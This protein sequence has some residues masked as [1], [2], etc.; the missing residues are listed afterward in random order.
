MIDFDQPA[1]LRY[2]H[3]Y[4][5]FKEGLL[6]LVEEF[7]YNYHSA[8]TRQWHMDHIDE[9]KES[10]PD[11]YE[12]NFALAS[13]LGLPVAQT[14]AVS[15]LPDH[16]TFCTSIV[17]RNRLGEISHVRNLDF[18]YAKLM[19]AL[20]YEAILVKDGSERARAPLIAGF[21]GVFT[22]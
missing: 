22:G 11:A 9:L 13:I 12:A 21:Y 1:S 10:Q 8:E 2:N 17:A 5:H 15:M 14:M 18:Q 7:W 6:P 3:L 19:Q 20:I 4:D 16:A